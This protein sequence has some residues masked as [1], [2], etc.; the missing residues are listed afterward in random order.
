MLDIAYI[1]E[2]SVGRARFS[3][4]LHMY[5]WYLYSFHTI[6]LYR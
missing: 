3:Q 1:A 6:Q 5:V 4:Y 2:M